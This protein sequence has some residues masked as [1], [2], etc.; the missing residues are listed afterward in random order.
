[1]EFRSIQT[2]ENPQVI[3]VKNRGSAI[4]ETNFFETEHARN[5]C[6]YISF[7]AGTARVLMP[8]KILEKADISDDV[9]EVII[10]YG[11]WDR[12]ED[13]GFEL[14]F[15]DNTVHPF[16]MYTQINMVNRLLKNKVVHTLPLHIYSE[17]GLER[18]FK[19]R[20]RRRNTIPYMK[21]W[22]GY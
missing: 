21:P 22:L 12:A 19:A 8:K 9:T 20:Y 11:Y 18:I 10:T 2:G 7:N 13:Y 15:E 17:D 16:C 14:L 3:T 1:M 6:F 4:E 5:G